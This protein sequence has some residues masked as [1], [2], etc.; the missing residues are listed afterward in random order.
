M[1]ESI[2]SHDVKQSDDGWVVVKQCSGVIRGERAWLREESGVSLVR[3][4]TQLE[5]VESFVSGAVCFCLHASLCSR[6]VPL[7]CLHT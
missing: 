5:R 7:V 1:C 2:C 6:F 4:A 3:T